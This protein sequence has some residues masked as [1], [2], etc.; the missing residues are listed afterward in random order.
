MTVNLFLSQFHRIKFSI[1]QLC[2]ICFPGLIKYAYKFMACC[3]VGLVFALSTGQTKDKVKGVYVE[4]FFSC[5]P[6]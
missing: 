6:T 1:N 3:V 5:F 2:S 4:C